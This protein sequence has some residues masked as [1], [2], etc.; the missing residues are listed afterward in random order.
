MAEKDKGR[1]GD[2]WRE[3]ATLGH[4]S[5]EFDAYLTGTPKT[6]HPMT[7]EGAAW[8]AGH[9][10][11]RGVVVRVTCTIARSTA[12]TV[13]VP[14][15]GDG[16]AKELAVRLRHAI[17]S[18]EGLSWPEGDVTLGVEG[19]PLT[20]SYVSDLGFAIALLR[21]SGQVDSASPAWKDVAFAAGLSLGG[22]LEPVR[23][24]YPAAEAVADFNMSGL[25]VAAATYNG[26]P[27]VAA[28]AVDGAR[29]RIRVFAESN[30]DELIASMHGL[31]DAVPWTRTPAREPDV[32]SE[33][34]DVKGRDALKGA[35]VLALAGDHPLVMVGD[36]GTVALARRAPSLLPPLTDSET[37]EIRRVAS[38]AGLTRRQGRPFRA[39][40]HT[41]S[42]D[43]LTGN[44]RGRVLPGEV[45]LA[46]HG[47][48]FLDDVH[49]FKRAAVS[50][51]RTVLDA[52]TSARDMPAGDVCLIATATPYRPSPGQDLSQAAAE[53]HLS[54]IRAQLDELFPRGGVIAVD[55]GIDATHP[56]LGELETLGLT[57]HDTASAQRLVVKLRGLAVARRGRTNGRVP[58]EVLRDAK[59]C[60]AKVLRTFSETSGLGDSDLESILRVARTVA[61]LRGDKCVALR[62]LRAASTLAVS[63]ST[64]RHIMEYAWRSLLPTG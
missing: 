59:W 27:G 9:E 13:S 56:L 57:G 25:V 50:A 32:Y 53:A 20:P 7:G 64:W 39:P 21:A 4:D 55:D 16:D 62:H 30:L 2:R 10:G 46:H 22:Y 14:C 51:L 60:H 33:L 29:G 45:T 15:M 61:D 17:R 43:A 19:P 26:E 58:I 37:W 49:L 54:P 44:S 42:V 18:T 38:V 6:N 48:L 47:V 41:I 31:Q 34:D 11:V 1:I 5:R 63:R 40:H 24:A 36:Y 3:M 8:V 23:G 12:P 28:D 35:M 52:G